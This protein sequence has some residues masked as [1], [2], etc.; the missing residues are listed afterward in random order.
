[1][2]LVVETAEISTNTN[3][4]GS[5]NLGLQ[6]IAALN[7]ENTLLSKPSTNTDETCCDE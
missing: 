6:A 5:Q 3:P 1:M 2:Y 7:L 4:T